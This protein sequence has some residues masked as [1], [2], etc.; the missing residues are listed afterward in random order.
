VIADGR[1]MVASADAHTVYAFDAKDGKPLWQY[2][3]GGRI[4]SPPTI[5]GGLAVFGSADGWVYCVRAADGQLAWRYRAAPEERRLV[6]FGQ[7]ESAWPVHGSVLVHDGSVYCA[8]GR[9]SYLDGGIWLC[10]LD[11]RTGKKLAAERIWSRDPRSGEQPAEPII[12]EMPGALP[13]ILSCDGKL[14][15]MRHL[16]FE[17]ANL[18]PRK[19]ASHLYSPAGF[20]NDDWWHRSYWIYGEH[21]YSGYIGWYFAGRETPAGR[22]LAIGD[23]AIYGFAYRPE[24]Y[25]T[26]TK[27]RY[28]LFAVNRRDVPP[29]PAADYARANR[30]YPSNGAGKHFVPL[31][32]SRESPLMTRAMLLAGETLLLAGPPANAAESK[33]AY[34]GAEGSILCAVSAADGKTLAA[35]RLDSLPTFDGLAASQGRVFLATQDGRLLCLSETRST[36]GGIELR[37]LDAN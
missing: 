29:Q 10:R 32:W 20:L 4:D 1:V 25:R 12:F 15:Y 35:Y 23:S 27:T 3:A 36:P 7:V 30:D 17:P 8:A 9:S 6:A 31:R 14:I 19:A 13:D 26:A 16:A 5:A 2:T 37:R 33:S 22:L 34:E 24:F 18:K 28:H 11:L 21:F